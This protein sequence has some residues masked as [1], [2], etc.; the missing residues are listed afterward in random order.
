MPNYKS[1][2]P[3]ALDWVLEHFSVTPVLSGGEKCGGRFPGP[4]PSVLGSEW[5]L[6]Q[7]LVDVL[8]PSGQSWFSLCHLFQLSSVSFPFSSNPWQQ[9]R[10]L[11]SELG[12]SSGLCPP[13]VFSDLAGSSQSRVL[14]A[15]VTLL[16]PLVLL[17]VSWLL[18]SSFCTGSICPGSPTSIFCTRTSSCFVLLL[19]G[20]SVICSTFW[21]VS[22]RCSS[23]RCVLSQFL[24]SPL[25][26]QLGLFWELVL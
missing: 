21:P 14:Q 3:S 22:G 17:S 5:T 26:A 11:S 10:L 18:L 24:L 9:G 23:A 7:G 20:P 1:S 2:V 25:P 13:Y 19:G 6:T 15:D 4:S 16:T 12:R 8:L